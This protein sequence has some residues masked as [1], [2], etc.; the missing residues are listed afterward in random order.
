MIS[1]ARF[2]VQVAAVSTQETRLLLTNRVLLL[3]FEIYDHKKYEERFG[4]G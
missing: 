1:F 2:P 3:P 4:Y